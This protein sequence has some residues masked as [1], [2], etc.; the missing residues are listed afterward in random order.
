MGEHTLD[1]VQEFGVGVRTCWATP[2]EGA[3]RCQLGLSI[4]RKS[5]NFTMPSPAPAHDH[6]QSCVQSQDFSI[7]SPKLIKGHGQ[8]LSPHSL[9]M[10]ASA[11]ES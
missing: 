4:F 2:G 9:S 1:L 10:T 5:Q 6:R 7:P 8:L 11:L 3:A